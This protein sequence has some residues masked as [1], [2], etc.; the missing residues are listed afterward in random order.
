M[1]SEVD[2]LID[3]LQL[4]IRLRDWHAVSDVAMDIREIEARGKRG[5]LRKSNKVRSRK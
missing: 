1:R 5:R 4:K 2:I 3:Y